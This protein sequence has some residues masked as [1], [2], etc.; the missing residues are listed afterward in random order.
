MH[1]FLRTLL[2]SLFLV[3][4]LAFGSTLKEDSAFLDASNILKSKN[5]TKE[6]IQSLLSRKSHLSNLLLSQINT[7]HIQQIKEFSRGKDGKRVFVA[8]VV[9]WLLFDVMALK[10]AIQSSEIESAEESKEVNKS[11]K[12]QNASSCLAWN[13]EVIHILGTSDLMAGTNIIWAAIRRGL[14]NEEWRIDENLAKQDR[15]TKMGMFFSEET[16]ET[17][18]KLRNELAELQAILWIHQEKELRFSKSL[19]L[20]YDLL[21]DP[22]NYDEAIA[23]AQNHFLRKTLQEKE[24]IKYFQGFLDELKPLLIHE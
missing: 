4:P 14:Y 13:R 12:P 18:Y 23:V 11:A 16:W 8:S 21:D 10:E 19:E 3:S 5:S 2:V 15:K 9:T 1:I 22:E 20:A 17:R 24:F 7:S 6:Q